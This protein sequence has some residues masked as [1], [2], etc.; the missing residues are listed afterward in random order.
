MPGRPS[1]QPIEQ[2]PPRSIDDIIQRDAPFL[3]PIVL[4][5]VGSLI[6][7]FV[8]MRSLAYL[9]AVRTGHLIR[10]EVYD[11]AAR[12]QPIPDWKPARRT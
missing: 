2:G 3:W 5:T 8:G 10:K 6:L 4:L 12:A 1:S 9:V 11:P 7:I